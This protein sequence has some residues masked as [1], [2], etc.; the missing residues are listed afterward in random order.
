M[1]TESTVVSELWSLP[2]LEVADRLVGYE[3]HST[4][5]GVHTAGIIAETEAYLPDDPASHSFRGQTSR[6]TPMFG[7]AGHI[8]VYKSY[9]MHWC[10][11]VV[12]D[13]VGIGAAVLIRAILPC[14]GKDVMRTRRGREEQIIDGP[15]KVCQALGISDA[16]NTLPLGQDTG[17]WL[18]FPREQSV[19]AVKKLPRI[20]ISQA[21][22]R[23][24]RFRLK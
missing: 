3:L 20:G 18:E 12:T 8:Y 11:N 22:D 1:R 7:P 17:L 23:L 6:N 9:G 2:T 5:G 21:K 13:Q 19:F 4:L 15:G 14:V 16:V 10:V 24:W